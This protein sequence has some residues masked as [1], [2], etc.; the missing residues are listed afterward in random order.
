MRRHE[1]EA[2]LAGAPTT[3]RTAAAVDRAWR[4]LGGPNGSAPRSRRWLAEAVARYPLDEVATG[5]GVERAVVRRLH[6]GL[7]LTQAEA[8]AICVWM[9]LRRQELAAERT[10][11]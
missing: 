3:K 2:C 6:A 4:A 7:P 5:A 1:L 8:R 11:A 10:A 9:V